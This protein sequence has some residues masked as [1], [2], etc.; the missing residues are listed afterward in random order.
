MDY[1]HF[2]VKL[3]ATE[4][5]N[6]HL[7][8]Q[9]HPFWNNKKTI[10]LDQDFL[11]WKEIITGAR[12]LYETVSNLFSWAKELYDSFRI[13]DLSKKT[14]ACDTEKEKSQA[15][16]KNLSTKE[17][18]ATTHKDLNRS[19][20]KTSKERFQE[21]D[22][23]QKISAT[24][25][26]AKA[27]ISEAKKKAQSKKQL[28]SSSSKEDFVKAALFSPLTKHILKACMEL[29]RTLL[30]ENNSVIK[31]EDQKNRFEKKNSSL[32]N[33][34]EKEKWSIWIGFSMSDTKQ[35]STPK[36]RETLSL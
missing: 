23:K 7:N 31:T 15:I 14:Y 29:G 30:K 1:K 2:S 35:G 33:D 12:S 32:K 11:N 21:P 3:T 24:S 22:S 34:K 26:K 25:E 8:A 27:T 4:S 5:G 13:Q 17:T 16:D 20:H 28:K 9:F 10:L 6:Y 18:E 19:S 36:R